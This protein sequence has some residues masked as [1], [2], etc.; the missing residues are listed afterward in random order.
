MYAIILLHV[1]Y[2]NFM[3][4]LLLRV[5][6]LKVA[7]EVLYICMSGKKKWSN[8]SGI[9][10][11]TRIKKCCRLQNEGKTLRWTTLLTQLSNWVWQQNLIAKMV[12]V[13]Y[14]HRIL[15]PLWIAKWNLQTHMRQSLEAFVG[16][17]FGNLC[18]E[19]EKL[20]YLSILLMIY[21]DLPAVL[22]YLSCHCSGREIS[23]LKNFL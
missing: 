15:S 5:L 20:F 18:K 16:L 3:H 19:E 12:V 11:T 4:S 7:C 2:R 17:W 23:F 10:S 22:Y 9:N 14:C 6:G 13:V 8:N 1:D 21:P